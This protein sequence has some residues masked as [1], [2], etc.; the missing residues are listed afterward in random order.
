M[1][2]FFR[3]NNENEWYQIHENIIR[4]SSTKYTAPSSNYG[5]TSFSEFI[6]GV[7]DRFYSTGA[8]HNTTLKVT[9]E[10]SSSDRL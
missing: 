6:S 4:K 9:T 8:C 7:S 1:I 5:N 2:Y 10:W 3:C